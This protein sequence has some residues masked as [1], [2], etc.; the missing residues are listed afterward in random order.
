MFFLRLAA[1][2]CR[3]LELNLVVLVLHHC[4]L[5]WCQLLTLGVRS[6]QLRQWTVVCFALHVYIH[7]YICIIIIMVACQGGTPATTSTSAIGATAAEVSCCDWFA[8]T[9]IMLEIFHCR[10]LTHDVAYQ[11]PTAGAAPSSLM[12]PALGDTAAE[13]SCCH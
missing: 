6:L 8:L 5:T 10:S 9:T 2:A 11:V 4:L 7:I 1:N 3:M 13:V 12:T